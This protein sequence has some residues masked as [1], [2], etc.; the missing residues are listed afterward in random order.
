MKIVGPP[1][2]ISRCKFYLACNEILTSHEL[3][4]AEVEQLRETKESGSPDEQSE[5]G[6]EQKKCYYN[7]WNVV[8]KNLKMKCYYCFLKYKIR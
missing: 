4:N 7:L 3:T 2:S 5:N 8:G 6:T 1:L